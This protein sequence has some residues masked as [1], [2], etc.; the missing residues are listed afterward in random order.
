MTM[1]RRI[2][3]AALLMFVGIGLPAYAQNTT[4]RVSITNAGA[5][6]NG[7]SQ[8]ASLS[9]DG[10]YIAFTSGATNLVPGDTNGQQDIFVRDRQLGTTERVNLRNGGAQALGGFSF[11]PSINPDGEFILFSSAATNLVANDTNDQFDVFVHNRLTNITI[12]V[13]VVSGGAQ[14]VGGGSIQA[15][16]T[17]DARY[18]AFASDATNLVTGDTNA[19]TDIFLHDRVMVTTQRVSVT[20]GGSQSLG[21]SLVPSLSANG[22]VVVFT[23][24]APDLVTGDTNGKFDVFVRDL[25][26]GTTTRV[27][28]G[29]SGAQGNED[30]AYATISGD[31]RFVAFWSGATTL[32]PNGGRGFYVHD[33]TTGVTSAL[34]TDS[35]QPAIVPRISRDGRYVC[36]TFEPANLPTEVFVIDRQTLAKTRVSVATN[37][38][39]ATRGSEGC[40]I[41]ADGTLV[42]YHSDAVNLVSGDTNGSYDVFLRTLFATMALDK[43]ALAFA[44]VTSGATFV[45]QTAPQSV[46]LLQSGS[47]TVTWTVASNQPWL[48]VSPAS[49]SGSGTLSVSV[50]PTAGLPPSGTVTGSVFVSLTGSLNAL[51]PIPVT[52]TLTPISTSVGPFGTVD[53]PTD[54]RTGVTG[55]VPFTG[56]ALDDIGVSRVSICR[57][58]FGAEVAPIDP[59][60]GG[61]AEIFVGFAVFIEGARPDV[62]AGFATYPLSTRAGWGFMVLTNMLPNRGNGT[63]QFRMRAQDHEGNWFVLGDPHDDVCERDRDVAL[64]HA[65]HAAPRW[66]R[67]RHQLHQFRLG[68]DAA[69]ENDSRRTDRRFA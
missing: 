36:V 23:S 1:G 8:E 26:A 49:G 45:S 58:A 30:S 32:V 68:A 44:A 37:G 57:A 69:A 19:N 16:M 52:L 48:Q 46:R 17:P 20:N 4:T 13:S 41:N 24:S 33:R 40:A 53:T 12:R 59:N 64:R 29:A 38:D 3:A 62:A 60:C 42:T 55:A 18:L 14:A 61:A 9:D 51:T 27:S 47:G 2:G 35:Q 56:W 63:Y 21:T 5:Q 50:V 15:V 31:G 66:H 10:R 28:V 67:L 39:S 65:R 34:S 43:T 22:Q 6:A 25:A 11:G 54:N 7:H